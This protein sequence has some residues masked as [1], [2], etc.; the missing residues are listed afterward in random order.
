MNVSYVLTKYTLIV[1]TLG[2]ARIIWSCQ[3]LNKKLIK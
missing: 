3:M 1:V 2:G